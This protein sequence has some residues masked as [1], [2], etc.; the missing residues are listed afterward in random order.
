MKIQVILIIVILLSVFACD[1][2]EIDFYESPNPRI[3]VSS[4]VGYAPFE[5]TFF[6]TSEEGS[7]PIQEWLWDFNGDGISDVIYTLNDVPDSIVFVYDTPAIYNAILTINDGRSQISDTVAIEV[8]N[9]NS[10]ISDFEYTQ[11]IIG[12]KLIDFTDNS[13]QGTNPIISWEWD[14]DNDGETDNT[15][16]NPTHTFNTFGSFPVRLTVSDG[17]YQN[18]ITKEILVIGKSVMIELFTSTSCTYC[19]LVES[20]LQ[21][22]KAEF[23]SRISYLE[24]HVGD[25]LDANS[26]DLLMYYGAAS[27]PTTVINGNQAII[28]GA[29][30]IYN[31]ILSNIQ[32][33]LSEDP[34]MIL[35]S[36]NVELTPDSL[37]G[38]VR[39]ENIGNITI[40][41]L[42][43][44]IALME[45]YNDDWTNHNGEYLHNIV[46]KRSFVDISQCDL[47]QPIDFSITDL[48]Q[49]P[50][51]YNELPE[52][53]TL[54]LWLQVWE[55]EYNDDTC[56]V[57]NVLEHS[58]Q[59]N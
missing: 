47:S 34:Q 23:G 2:F 45:D 54:V 9:A 18:S 33:L 4:Q 21:D 30:D 3:T 17:L 7:Q 57:H 5:V 26:T 13:I 8:L 12:Q 22:I 55:D 16:Q 53:L 48:C 36:L 24:Y 15:E 28:T 46:L 41:D 20:A 38:N 1:R 19:P 39:V 56:T 27:L 59:N 49:L 40:A 52:D 42:K 31:R 14:F 11:P 6:D 43:L 50:A 10:P 32:P 25:E 58:L 29:D 35:D 37:F 44:R 51:G